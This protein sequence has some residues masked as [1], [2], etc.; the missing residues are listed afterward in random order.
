MPPPLAAAPAQ[1]LGHEDSPVDRQRSARVGV[2]LPLTRTCLAHRLTGE[3]ACFGQHTDGV[4]EHLVMRGH[5]A[6]FGGGQIA[7]VK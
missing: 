3:S 1:G 7:R 2:G 4:V 6:A 5:R